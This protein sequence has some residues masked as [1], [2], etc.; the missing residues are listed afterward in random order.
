M[1]LSR[2]V[3]NELNGLWSNGEVSLVMFVGININL[4]V[5]L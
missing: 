1:Y 2:P 3:S 5:T 4:N